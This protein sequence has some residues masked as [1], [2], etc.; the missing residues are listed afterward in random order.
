MAITDRES[1]VQ[2]MKYLTSN[3]FSTLSGDMLAYGIGLMLLNQTGSAFSFGTSMIITPLVYLFSLIPIGNLVDNYKH[4]PILVVSSLI[5]I[6]ALAFLVIV[7]NHFTGIDKLIPIIPFLIINSV[8]TNASTT[9]YYS[10][11]HELV[12]QHK[13]KSLSSLNNAVGSFASIFSPILGVAI[14]SYFGFRLFIIIEIC[15]EIITL[16]ITLSMNFYYGKNSRT[17]QKNVKRSQ[18]GNFKAGLKYISKRRLITDLIVIGV[19]LNFIFSSVNLGLPYI[20][21]ITLKASNNLIG[22]LNTGNAIGILLGSLLC[23]FMSDRK[24]FGMKIIFPVFSIGLLILLLGILFKG[25]YQH[26]FY[27]NLRLFNQ[28]L[29]RNLTINYR[30]QQPDSAARNR[31]NYN[32]GSSNRGPDYL[33]QH[34]IPGRNLNLYHPV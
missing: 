14:Y 13:I 31:T 21:R 19:F 30:N 23:N 17:N 6:I 7:I 2:I 18:F 11:V 16:L 22:Y 9:T 27:W 26:H 33:K 1:N 32:S 15:S 5:R 10:A 29:N 24:R 4:Q 25:Y 34:H 20:I 12:N 28:R 8:C 3:L